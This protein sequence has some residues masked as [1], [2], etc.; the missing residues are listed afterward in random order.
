MG[1]G[2]LLV[3]CE[4]HAMPELDWGKR[5]TRFNSASPTKQNAHSSRFDRVL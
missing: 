3:G 5:P 1:N 4:P 2:S